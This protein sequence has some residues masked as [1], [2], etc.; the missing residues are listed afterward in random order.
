MKKK[1]ELHP[2]LSAMTTKEY[3]ALWPKPPTQQGIRPL[4]PMVVCDECERLKAENEA[5]KAK[6]NTLDEAGWMLMNDLYS[7]DVDGK[8]QVDGLSDE[9]IINCNAL[10]SVLADNRETGEI[11]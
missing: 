4:T 11:D 2:A 1:T 10:L 6:L 7:A 8:C 9:T 3:D 5:L